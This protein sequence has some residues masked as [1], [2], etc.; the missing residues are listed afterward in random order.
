MWESHDD[1]WTKRCAESTWSICPAQ[2]VR[3]YSRLQYG[4]TS[5]ERP[6]VRNESTLVWW[7]FAS[8]QGFGRLKERT[9]ETSW[10]L[11]P[12]L[13]E[14]C[15]SV[16]DAV[17][18]AHIRACL[19]VCLLS[20]CLSV[21][22]RNTNLRHL[23]YCTESS[24]FVWQRSDLSF[25]QRWQKTQL[26]SGV[27]CSLTCKIFADVSENILNMNHVHPKHYYNFAILKDVI[28]KNILNLIST[29]V[30][31]LDVVQPIFI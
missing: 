22:Q 9:S 26:S 3:H 31:T 27:L 1:R 2:S 7:V 10:D 21:Q 8:I 24:R 30:R 13:Q 25:F 4:Y 11:G 5:S 15:V 29:A 19:S 16:F 18:F 20:V 17:H 23:N 28:F 12:C 6:T 14:F